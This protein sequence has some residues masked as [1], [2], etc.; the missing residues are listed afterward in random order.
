MKNEFDYL[1]D[2]KI[3]F[4]VYKNEILTKKEKENMKN[5][6]KNK[7]KVNLK[8]YVTLA[9]C[10]T[11]SV[12]LGITAYAAGWMDNVI[13]IISTGHNEFA[14]VDTSDMEA[15]VP[16]E[17]QGLLFD[18]DGKELTSFRHDT[19]LY[20]KNGNIIDDF[21]EYMKSQGIEEFTTEDGT[22]KIEFSE[23]D[24]ADPLK[25]MEDDY[26]IVKDIKELDNKKGFKAKL[27][28]YIPE[29]FNFYGA[30]Y[31]GDEGEYLF[32][33]YINKDGEY[34]VIHERLINDETAYATGAEQI[35]LIEIN[36]KKAVLLDDNEISWEEDGISV[37]ILGR[38]VL[39]KDELV[40]V[41][42]SIR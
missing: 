20:D 36:G 6:V 32:I 11:I 39:E 4:S 33:Y 18:A 15:K 34:F 7:R 1:N 25:R 16:K 28:E 35:D 24:D 14:Q 3:D 19:V 26:T 27:P 2:V 12:A 22:V 29:G 8:K 31:S 41:A 30:A 21:N 10:I 40:K 23:N 17:L 5:T 37:D 38:K 42:E 13:K 9:A